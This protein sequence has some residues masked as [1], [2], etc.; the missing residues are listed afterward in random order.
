MP[1]ILRPLAPIVLLLSAFPASASNCWIT[2]GA[3]ASFGTLVTGN[4][5]TTQSS[6]HFSCY[7]DTGETRYFNVCLSSVE[8][9]PFKMDSNG[10]EQ[11]KVY[12]MLFRLYSALD[13]TRELTAQ[14]AGRAL[15]TPLTVGSNLVGSGSFPLRAVIP[16]G[17]NPLPVR[18]YFNYSLG[19]KLTWNSATQREALSDCADGAAQ[20]E[21]LDSSSSASA[22]LSDSCL[23]QSVSPLN[24]G[25]VN[26]TA[27]GAP[28]TSTATIRARCPVGTRYMLGLS[29]GEHATG[30]RRQMCNAQQQC[31]KYDLWQD[32][33]MTQPWGDQTGSNTLEVSHHDGNLQ[34]VTVYG[35]VPTQTLNGT[36][37][38]SDDVV[39]T[40]TY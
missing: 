24:F 33:A 4:A 35:S 10:D 8:A 31:L 12:S 36:G 1:I 11:G 40:L 25:T 28:V 21:A 18:S 32:G 15:Q 7:A 17:Q 19:L 14:T 22:T 2:Q 27:M 39:V 37:E 6:V 29:A 13:N 16:A 20:G 23:I 5:A 38:F 30:Q 26:S 3:T 34:D 9:S